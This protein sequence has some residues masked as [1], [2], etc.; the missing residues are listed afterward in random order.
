MLDSVDSIG[1]QSELINQIV[2][3]HIPFIQSIPE[4]L[5]G[6]HINAPQR[7][8]HAMKQLCYR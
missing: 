7:Q 6:N 8:K 3:G 2:C 5:V 4:G 1:G